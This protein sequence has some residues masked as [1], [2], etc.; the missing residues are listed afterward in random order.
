MVGKICDKQICSASVP[1][2]RFSESFVSCSLHQRLR[3]CM[4]LGAWF[5]DRSFKTLDPPAPVRR[6]CPVH[7]SEDG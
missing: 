3:P 6:F 4:P 2:R 1:S 7:G 5:P